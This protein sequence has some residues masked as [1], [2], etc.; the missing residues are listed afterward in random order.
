MLSEPLLFISNIN[1]I[2]FAGSLNTPL[3]VPWVKGA[4]TCLNELNI[5]KINSNA[6]KFVHLKLYMPES[7]INN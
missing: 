5:I 7:F 6:N 3:Q 4:E 2:S 1:G